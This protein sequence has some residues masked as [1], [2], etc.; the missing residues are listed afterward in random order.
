MS[1]SLANFPNKGST[2]KWSQPQKIKMVTILIIQ[3]KNIMTEHVPDINKQSFIFQL[4]P[5]KIPCIPKLEEVGRGVCVPSNEKSYM[6]AAPVLYILSILY[7][8]M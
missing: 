7:I 6:Y 3:Q 8:L 1:S 2:M 5:K 4:Y